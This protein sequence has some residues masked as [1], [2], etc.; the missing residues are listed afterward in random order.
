M[1]ARRIGWRSAV[2]AVSML[3]LG[4]PTL[5]S[6]GVERHAFATEVHVTFTDRTL[7]VTPASLSQTGP[8]MIMV[9]NN[10][11]K[12]HVLTITGPGVKGVR[13]QRVSPGGS[14]VLH[15]NLL[16]GSYALSDPGLGKAKVRR[17]IVTSNV[18]GPPVSAQ[19]P[20]HAPTNATTTTAMD[21]A[22]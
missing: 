11:H 9:A 13:T 6:A 14:A 16:T 7:F 3:A 18:V 5:T 10:G 15:L 2:I 19:T 8:A 1:R 20:Q 21:C 22:L 4:S 12:L 17:L